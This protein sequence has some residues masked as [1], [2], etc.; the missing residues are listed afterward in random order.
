LKA[1]GTPR[2][3]LAETVDEMLEAIRARRS[4]NA[5]PGL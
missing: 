3:E 4:R 2:P 1:I 5:A